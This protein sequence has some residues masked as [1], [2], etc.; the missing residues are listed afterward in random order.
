VVG[1]VS[2]VKHNGLESEPSL[3][4]YAPFAQMAYPY[5]SIMLRAS[6]AASFAAAI[7]QEVQAVDNDQPVHDVMMMEQWV[8]R[9]VA[10]RRLS[11]ALFTLFGGVAMLLAGIGIYGV[12]SYTVTQRTHEI[13]VRMALGAERRDVLRLVVGQG[14]RLAVVGV[15]VGLITALAATRLMKS[16]LF[17]VSATDVMT[18]I[19]VATVL[20]LVALGA[21]F[22]PALR[23]TRVDPMVAL[24][25]E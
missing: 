5:L 23:A 8:S 2:D 17:A 20:I 4:A 6:N 7:R 3:E 14:M 19:A 10:P 25:Y 13:G 12:M 18:F 1:V 22:V 16:L 24:R 9:S 15:A 21:C 11:M